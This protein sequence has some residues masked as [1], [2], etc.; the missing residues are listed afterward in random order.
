MFKFFE[1]LFLSFFFFF[2]NSAQI[3]KCLGVEM[4]KEKKISVYLEQPS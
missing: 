1:A 4:I 3:R 2:L